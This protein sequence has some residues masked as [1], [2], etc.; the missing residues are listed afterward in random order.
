MYDGDE[1]IEQIENASASKRMKAEE[2]GIKQTPASS[3]S[4]TQANSDQ[5]SLLTLGGHTLGVNSASF[6]RKGRFILTASDDKTAR[7]WDLDERG[8]QEFRLLLLVNNRLIEPKSNT[9]NIV[10]LPRDLLNVIG[11]YLT[12]VTVTHFTDSS[13]AQNQQA[14]LNMESTEDSQSKDLSHSDECYDHGALE[15]GYIN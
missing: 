15:V 10:P 9:K 7:V 4:T 6:S 2:D 3:S 5:P 12:R 13:N 8:S 14:T 1:N 11:S